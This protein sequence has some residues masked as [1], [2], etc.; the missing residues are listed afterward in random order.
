VEMS[1][2]ELIK[3][4]PLFIDLYDDEIEFIIG[5]CNVELFQKGDIII[6]DGDDG[7]ELFILLKGTA[8]VSKR[9][10]SG[11]VKY[12]TKLHE[13]DMF[14]ETSL[15]EEPRSAD[16]L[17]ETSCD[18]LS[19]NKEDLLKLYPKK[20][21]IFAVIAMNMARLLAKRLKATNKKLR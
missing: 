5:K 6:R 1:A 12:I 15:I 11:E 2:V 13:G 3:S 7:N 19:I 21:K 8:D 20:S 17:A 14:G 9:L 16:V 4:C 18:V 10:A